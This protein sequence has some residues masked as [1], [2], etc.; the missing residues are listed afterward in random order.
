M[1]WAHHHSAEHRII[2]HN[3]NNNNKTAIMKRSMMR[4]G[5]ECVPPMYR[6]LYNP[7]GVHITVTE[8][9]VRHTSLYCYIIIFV[10]SF[11]FS[12][13][14]TAANSTKGFD[15][16]TSRKACNALWL[17]GSCQRRRWRLLLDALCELQPEMGCEG[18]RE[19]VVS[20]KNAVKAS[21]RTTNNNN[22]AR[23][24]CLWYQ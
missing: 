18:R 17:L 7:W 13:G 23:K 11:T 10:S 21:I 19:S 12:F 22:N 6:L 4:D 2:T 24:G 9:H 3:K 16:N 1:I 5:R 8:I 14:H 20:F 15:A